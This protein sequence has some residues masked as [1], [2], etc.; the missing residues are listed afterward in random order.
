M[1]NMLRIHQGIDPMPENLGHE[2][3]AKTHE[4]RV[5][6]QKIQQDPNC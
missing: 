2:R 3:E 4:T 1:E 5:T 6:Y